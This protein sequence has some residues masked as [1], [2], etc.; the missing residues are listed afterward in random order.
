M[1]NEKNYGLA[2]LGV[3]AG[4]TPDPATGLKRFL[5]IRL[6]HMY[7]KTQMRLQEDSPFKSLVKFTPDSQTLPVMCLKQELPLSK[8]GTLVFQH[9]VVLQ[10]SHMQF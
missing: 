10:Q 3:R 9:Q 2:T 6:L 5:F 4:Q 7:L 1:T 8:A